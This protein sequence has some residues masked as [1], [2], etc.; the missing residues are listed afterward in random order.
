MRSNVI[1]LGIPIKQSR[2]T[3]ATERWGRSIYQKHTGQ[4]GRKKQEASG[5]NNTKGEGKKGK[6]RQI[7]TT[8]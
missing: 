5:E 1:K 6:A 2:F 8:F 4:C 3:K 7:E